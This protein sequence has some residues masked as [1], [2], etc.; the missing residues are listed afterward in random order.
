MGVSFSKYKDVN[1]NRLEFLLVNYDYIDGNELIAQIMSDE[2][3]FRI[4]N[5]TDGIWYK[6]IQ[7][8][9]DDSTYE[10]LWHEDDGNSIYSL[11]QTDS[12][13]ELLEERLKRVVGILN[14]R[15]RDEGNE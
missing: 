2:F 10:M 1:R 6:I 14:V 9:L 7:I 4:V 8:K 13:N 12:E 11:S 5:Q 15:L 3:G